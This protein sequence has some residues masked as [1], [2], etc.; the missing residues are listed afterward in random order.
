M[1][2]VT[3]DKVSPSSDGLHL[4]T[5]VRYSEG[6]PVRFVQVLLPWS[7]FDRDARAAVLAQFDLMVEQWLDT[8][9]DQPEL[10]F[11]GGDW[12]SSVPS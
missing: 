4:G 9:P 3:V 12:S 5:I 7:A 1:I 10:P 8:E 11:T 6:G 2:T